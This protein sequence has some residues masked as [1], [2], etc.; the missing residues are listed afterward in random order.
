M[1]NHL[2]VRCLRS[3]AGTYRLEILDLL[4]QGFPNHD[5]NR[6][7]VAAPDPLPGDETHRCMLRADLIIIRE[8]ETADE[9]V[10]CRTDPADLQAMGEPV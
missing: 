2:T 8:E 1:E 9:F 5:R 4:H 7:G 6:R 10:E 3:T